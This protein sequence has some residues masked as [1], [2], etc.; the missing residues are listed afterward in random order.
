[1]GGL[2]LSP[3]EC[4]R[5]TGEERK[6]ECSLYALLPLCGYDDALA[7][8]RQSGHHA[9]L[10]EDLFDTLQSEVLY[11]GYLK[12]HDQERRMVAEHRKKRIPETFSYDAL[13]CLS[14]EERLR[15]SAA[16]PKTM[17]EARNLEG[18]TP[19]ALA[20]ILQKLKKGPKSHP[21]QDEDL[22]QEAV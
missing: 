5:L 7:L 13:V 21:E 2:R 12:R 1:M 6:S 16:R 20:A 8:L 11:A 19:V 3:D 10:P 17:E 15:L 9:P 14:A 18:I 22:F 4:S